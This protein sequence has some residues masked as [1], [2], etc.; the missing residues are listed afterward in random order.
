MLRQRERS[1]IVSGS[2]SALSASLDSYCAPDCACP[3]RG[4]RELVASPAFQ[5]VAMGL[6]CSMEFI[7]A[8][9]G[10]AV[11]VTL[12]SWL[13]RRNEKRAATERLLVEAI[14]DAV[15]GVAGVAQ[16]I[17]DAQ[18][19]YAAALARVALHGSPEV[20]RAFSHHQE[21]ATTITPG[22]RRRL[23]AAMQQARVELGGQRLDGRNLEV[24]LF[25][26]MPPSARSTSG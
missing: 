25:G 7:A 18:A 11:G 17:P 1:G 14:G 5:P 13:A 4:L 23:M 12:G 21:D 24:L 26:P 3:A 15:D 2:S 22:G 8:L 16:G 20:V 6:S 10:G 19:R 9:A